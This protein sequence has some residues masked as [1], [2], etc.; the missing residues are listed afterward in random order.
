MRARAPPN[1][2]RRQAPRRP[3]L[4]A[5]LSRELSPTSLARP[6]VAGDEAD[7]AL[8]QGVRQARA[9]VRKLKETEAALAKRPRGGPV[10]IDLTDD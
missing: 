3:L 10:T 5:P 7:A 4:L 8:P 9:N 1:H 2:A 6:R